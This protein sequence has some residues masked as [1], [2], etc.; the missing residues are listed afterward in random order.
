M[1]QSQLKPVDVQKLWAEGGLG[2]ESLE[3]LQHTIWWLI[4][5]QMGTR[6]CDEHHEFCVGDSPSSQPQMGW[7][8]LSSLLEGAQ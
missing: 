7:S 3:Q 4:S 8:T 2:G 5:A 1:Q 6:G